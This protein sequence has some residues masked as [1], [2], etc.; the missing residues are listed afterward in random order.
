MSVSC[1]CMPL[2]SEI[3]GHTA[4]AT[5]AESTGTFPWATAWPSS[6]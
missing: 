2:S 4:S 1:H 6:E 3:S 5:L